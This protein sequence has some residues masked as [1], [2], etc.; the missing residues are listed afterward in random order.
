M[1]LTEKFWRFLVNRLILEQQQM[2]RPL[3]QCAED[4]IICNCLLANDFL[5]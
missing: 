3:K 5:L 2:A 1:I 4:S